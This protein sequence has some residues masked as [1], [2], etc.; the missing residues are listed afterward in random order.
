MFVAVFLQQFNFWNKAIVIKRF[1]K[2]MYCTVWMWQYYIYNVL[3]LCPKLT[4]V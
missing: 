2:W 4:Y 3:L 1:S